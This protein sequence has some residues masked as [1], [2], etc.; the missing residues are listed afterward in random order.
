MPHTFQTPDRMRHPREGWVEIEPPQKF[1]APGPQIGDNAK[2]PVPLA[3]IDAP[4]AF[5]VLVLLFGASVQ[6][7]KR[8][9]WLY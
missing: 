2:L 1:S 5:I 6:R 4:G 9:L 7:R 3:F 8:P